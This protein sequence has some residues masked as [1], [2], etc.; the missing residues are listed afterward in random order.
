MWCKQFSAGSRLDDRL[1][2][3]WTSLAGGGNQGQWYATEALAKRCEEVIIS[4]CVQLMCMQGPTHDTLLDHRFIVIVGLLVQG[5][6][7]LYSTQ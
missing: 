5:F 4:F 7:R 2:A 1:F 6:T 3:A